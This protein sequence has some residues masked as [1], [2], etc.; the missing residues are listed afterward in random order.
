MSL[1][2]P[3]DYSQIIQKRYEHRPNFEIQ[4]GQP[5]TEWL[6]N[7]VQIPSLMVSNIN[8]YRGHTL[9]SLGEAAQLEYDR[10][11]EN[12]LV[13]FSSYLD[14][15]PDAQ[16]QFIRVERASSSLPADIDLV[17]FTDRYVC[18]ISVDGKLGQILTERKD[19]ST[20]RT[21]RILSSD[22]WEA[23]ELT[24][25]VDLRVGED[26]TLKGKDFEKIFIT[27]IIL[28]CG[29]RAGVTVGPKT[30]G[31]VRMQIGEKIEDLNTAYDAV[32]ALI[33]KTESIDVIDQLKE[34][35]RALKNAITLAEGRKIS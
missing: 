32:G 33:Q 19:G 5:L 26:I 12:S 30:Y 27:P 14:Q 9:G 23:S 4:P 31:N 1:Q 21:L 6:T 34:Q 16:E 35:A 8:R 24:E 2:P 25:D 28:A 15:A 10:K 7:T 3:P 29:E 22:G 20:K 17:K 11:L 13:E 18:F